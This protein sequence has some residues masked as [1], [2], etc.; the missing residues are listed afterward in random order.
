MD[1]WEIICVLTL[2]ACSVV[3]LNAKKFRKHCSVVSVFVG[4]LLVGDMIHSATGIPDGVLGGAY[5]A[6]VVVICYHKLKSLINRD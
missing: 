3:A 4:G 1:L 6:A 5:A 2:I